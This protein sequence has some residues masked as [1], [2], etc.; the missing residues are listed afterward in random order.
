MIETLLIAP[1]TRCQAVPK[2]APSVAARLAQVLGAPARWMEA[3]QISADLAALSERE[4]HDIGAG[5]R[6]S[7]CDY[8]AMESAEDRAAR[9][10][11]ARAWGASRKLAA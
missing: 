1:L 2:R 8:A 5:P 9:K 7:G 4:W 10:I 11:A 6:D 3:R